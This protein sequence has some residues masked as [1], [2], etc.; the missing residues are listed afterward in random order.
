MERW[1]VTWRRRWP[2]GAW[3]RPSIFPTFH[4][5]VAVSSRPRLLD[6]ALKAGV[7]AYRVELRVP[8]VVPQTD[9][10]RLQTAENLERPFCL[11]DAHERGAQPVGRLGRPVRALRD[12]SE[13]VEARQSRRGG[14]SPDGGQHAKR[15]RGN[16]ESRAEPRCGLRVA[17]RA[18]G[19]AQMQTCRGAEGVGELKARV[20][21][22]STVEPAA[23]LSEPPCQI[24]QVGE[25]DQRDG[26]ILLEL[27]R[28]MAS[29]CGR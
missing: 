1:K 16:R 18:G 15:L 29:R 27:Q 10:P 5:S 9:P 2:S 19:I 13:A 17:P 12:I 28:G 23:G 7:R 8:Q 26:A 22:E 21:G 24:A 25:V 20:H 3:V 4:P 11:S 14:A 6:Q